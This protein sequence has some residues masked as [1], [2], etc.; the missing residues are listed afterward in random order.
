MIVQALAKTKKKKKVWAVGAKDDG[1]IRIRYLG[2]ENFQ[3]YREIII[4][5]VTGSRWL[6][7]LNFKVVEGR[8][9]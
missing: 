5:G 3:R 6:H 1:T 8:I 7:G 4:A 9:T 2:S